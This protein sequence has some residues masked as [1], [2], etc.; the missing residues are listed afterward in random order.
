VAADVAVAEVAAVA[1]QVPV[2]AVALQADKVVAGAATGPVAHAVAAAR[3]RVATVTAGAAT[4]AASSS[5]T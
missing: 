1:G 2:V 5:R 3:A 4:V